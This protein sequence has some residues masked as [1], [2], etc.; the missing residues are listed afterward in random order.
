NALIGIVAVNIAESKIQNILRSLISSDM[1]SLFIINNKGIIVSHTNYEF[2][3]KAIY[4]VY[5]LESYL[6]K[7]SNLRSSCFELKINNQRYLLSFTT[8]D[9]TDWKY[10]TLVPFKRAFNLTYYIVTTIIIVSVAAYIVGLIISLSYVKRIY[11]PIEYL[12]ILSMDILKQSGYR[13]KMKNI[14]HM[15][16]SE[17]S[18]I[19]NAMSELK[20]KVLYIENKFNENIPQIKNNFVLNLVNGCIDDYREIQYKLNLFGIEN[21]KSCYKLILFSID[22]Y[23]KMRERLQ[24]KQMELIR[25][26]LIDTIQTSF[27]DNRI[28][29]VAADNGMNE[30]INIINYDKLETSDKAILDIIKD[31]QRMFKE[32]YNTSISA[33][34]GDEC[35]SLIDI[36]TSYSEA[37]NALKY[38]FI[39]GDGKILIYSEISK[40][41]I[42]YEFDSRTYI[43]DMVKYINSMDINGSYRVLENMLKDLLNGGYEIECIQYNL[44]RL[45]EYLFDTYN[46]N[47]EC[48]G[49]TKIHDIAHTQYRKLGD[50]DDYKELVKMVLVAIIES[51]QKKNNDINNK[52]VKGVSKYI[53]ENI[54]ETLSVE[55]IA[56]NFYISPSY[57]HK[58]FKE[59]TGETINNFIINERMKMAR[60]ML[61]KGVKIG[62]IAEKLNYCNTQYFIKQFKMHHGMTPKQFQVEYIGNSLLEN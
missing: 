31:I 57:L 18:V 34:V 19:E 56:H 37:K 22:G 30:F 11:S 58:I 55:E 59:E 1:E 13:Q 40:R 53:Q 41:H 4:D 45:I 5:N 43:N 2:I 28:N 32:S 6:D 52:L 23:D 47:E 51:I 36:G 14:N 9:L 8:S 46:V 27:K 21:L 50:L 60:V 20:Q 61:K 62:D 35:T 39:Y 49:D 17:C 25:L 33:G 15:Q 16:E 26:G 29:I 54:M 24:N 7:I 42:Y 38:N 44:K 48:K 12:A 3:N 10:I